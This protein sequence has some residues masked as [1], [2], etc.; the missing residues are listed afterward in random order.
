MNIDDIQK[1]VAEL[2]QANTSFN[3]LVIIEQP[4]TAINEPML[5][6]PKPLYDE[7]VKKFKSELP[8]PP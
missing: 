5:Y 6:L 7:A 3:R 4:N 2:G 1:I 8:S